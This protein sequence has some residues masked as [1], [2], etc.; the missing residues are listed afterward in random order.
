M[1]TIAENEA[2][3]CERD[4]LAPTT[5]DRYRMMLRLYINGEPASFTRRGSTEGKPI[6]K[7]GIGDVRVTELTRAHVR[8]WWQACR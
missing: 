7:A 3:Y 1:P 2:K 4:D 6:V 5:R 8:Q